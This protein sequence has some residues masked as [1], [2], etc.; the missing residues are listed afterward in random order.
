MLPE[1]ATAVL[2]CGRLG[3][4]YVPL[5]SG[6]GAEAVAS[7]LRDCEASLLITAD[8]FPRRG[9]VVPM[10]ATADAALAEAPGIGRCLVLRRTGEPVRSEERRVGKECRSRW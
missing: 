6:F 7:R 8:G 5:F 9:Q 3:A 2:A 1:T 10:K 4:V